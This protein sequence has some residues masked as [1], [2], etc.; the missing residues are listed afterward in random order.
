MKRREGESF[1][2]NKKA[3]LGSGLSAT[4]YT[5]NYS[6]SLLDAAPQIYAGQLHTV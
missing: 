1:A 5:E 2:Y 4:F 6:K 3:G